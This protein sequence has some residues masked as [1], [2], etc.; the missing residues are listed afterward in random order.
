[1]AEQDPPVTADV[2]VIS[3][4]ATTESGCVALPLAAV[5]HPGPDSGGT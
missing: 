2:M 4:I 3:Q 1:M 5:S